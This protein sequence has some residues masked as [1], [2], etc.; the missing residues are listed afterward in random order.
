VPE[1]PFD[2]LVEEIRRVVREEMQAAPESLLIRPVGFLDVDRAAEYLSTTPGAVRALVKRR[3][4]PV[5]KTPQ[6][7]LL[8][9]PDELDI[10]VRGG[11]ARVHH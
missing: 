7:R 10:Y 8:F 4:V 9:D 5:H 1:S 6:G 3:Q 2:A 11:A